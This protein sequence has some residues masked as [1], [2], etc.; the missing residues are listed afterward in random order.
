MTIAMYK[1]LIIDGAGSWKGRIRLAKENELG[2]NCWAAYGSSAISAPV[3][4]AGSA[5]ELE[6]AAAELETGSGPGVV[7]AAK[8]LLRAALPVVEVNCAAVENP[9]A[10]PAAADVR[11]AGRSRGMVRSDCPVSQ[12]LRPQLRL[13]GSTDPVRMEFLIGTGVAVEYMGRQHFEPLKFFG[14]DATFRLLVE[15]DRKKEQLCKD[16]GVELIR[17]RFDEDV[18][19][20][21]REIAKQI[22][23]AIAGEP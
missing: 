1:L 5:D 9:T 23:S 17:V 15:R 16:H 20:R 18:G 3:S 13:L 6:R 7:A 22:S 8:G 14:G 4:D 12:W 10:V 11:D 19:D 21:A 2:G